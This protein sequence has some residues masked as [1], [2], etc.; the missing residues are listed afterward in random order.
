MSDAEEDVVATIRQYV[1]CAETMDFEGRK[2]LWD[3]E[4]AMPILCPEES[5]IAL[6]GWDALDAYWAKSRTS[7]A[8]LKAKATDFRV[9]I[10]AD[11]IAFATYVSRWIATM[12]GPV[13]QVPIS[14]DVRM[15]AILRKR[16]VGWRYVQLVEG[17]VDLITMSR[18][19]AQRKAEELFPELLDP[20]Q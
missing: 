9:A 10:L 3:R 6:I 2:A 12:A 5:E 17:P 8:S 11:D 20:G 18:L 19:S 4:E 16:A 7:M 1:A 13:P 14:A 15:N